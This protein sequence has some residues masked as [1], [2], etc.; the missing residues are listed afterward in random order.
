MIGAANHKRDQD[1]PSMARI[2]PLQRLSRLAASPWVISFI[3]FALTALIIRLP[4][5]TLA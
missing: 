2:P 1:S 3:S 5:L 4:G